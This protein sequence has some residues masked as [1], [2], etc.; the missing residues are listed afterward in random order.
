LTTKIHMLADTLGR[1][2]RFI[3]TPGQ[4]LFIRP[5]CG[6]LALGRTVLAENL[7]GEALR[8]GELRHDMIDAAP[9]AGGAQ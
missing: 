1:P 5:A 8:D 6:L 2:L 9:T 7:A 3:L 4:R